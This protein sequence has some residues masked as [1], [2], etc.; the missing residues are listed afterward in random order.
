MEIDI[1]EEVLERRMLDKSECKV[2]LFKK[3]VCCVCGYDG[4]PRE[5][6]CGLATMD[7]VFALMRE[8]MKND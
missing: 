5:G 6:D 1:I 2:H 7:E 8:K 4:E 3:G